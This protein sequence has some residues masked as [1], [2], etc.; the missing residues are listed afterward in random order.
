VEVGKSSTKPL[1]VSCIPA[2][3]TTVVMDSGVLVA[4]SAP[5]TMS[6]FFPSLFLGG[7]K[8]PINVTFS[9]TSLG[10]ATARIRF[11]YSHGSVREAVIVANAVPS[12]SVAPT[13]SSS[14]DVSVVPNPFAS[15]T[16]VTMRNVSAT[17]KV[18]LTDLLGRVFVLPTAEKML[19][20]AAAL[21]LSK[22]TYVLRVEDGPV[23]ISRTIIHLQ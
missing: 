23:N 16:V 10:P 14:L 17:A 5:F 19:I 7:A 4:G 9:P 22:G 8:K 20:D 13:S 15:Q 12:S 11:Y 1:L 18:T 2:N 3:A 6:S 21:G